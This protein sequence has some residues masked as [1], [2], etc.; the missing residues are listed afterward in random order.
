MSPNSG[1]SS[2]QFVIAH[3]KSFTFDSY[4]SF[5][6]LIA[7]VSTDLNGTTALVGIASTGPYDTG[8]GVLSVNKLIVALND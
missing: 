3:W 8:T 1:A 7:A 4:S 2:T 6:D 5:S